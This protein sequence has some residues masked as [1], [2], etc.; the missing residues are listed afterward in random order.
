MN[1][2]AIYPEV[3]INI[4]DSEIYMETYV[5]FCNDGKYFLRKLTEMYVNVGMS[6]K[7]MFIMISEF[8]KYAYRILLLA[9]ADERDEKD[10]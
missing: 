1:E 7:E 8:N 6:Q 2:K 5:R 9:M 10:I 4:G 3:Y